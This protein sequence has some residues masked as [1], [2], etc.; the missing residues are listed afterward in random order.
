MTDS[1]IAR[2]SHGVDG[3]VGANARGQQEEGVDA[4][5]RRFQGGRLPEVT[6]G[7]F[8]ARRQS[9]GAGRLANQRTEWSA[10]GAEFT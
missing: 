7:E 2:R 5:K 3:V 6:D 8:R 4:G 9:D 10:S 1:G